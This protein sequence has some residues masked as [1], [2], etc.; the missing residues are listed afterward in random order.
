[1]AIGDVHGDHDTFKKLLMKASLIDEKENWI[2][3]ESILMQ[4]GD[5][6]DRGNRS[7]ECIDLII[8]LEEESRNH[9]GEVKIILG[10]HE[11]MNLIGFYL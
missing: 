9:G 6:L 10:N 1:M 8:K 5:L 4:M 3:G 7:K 2:G 11:V